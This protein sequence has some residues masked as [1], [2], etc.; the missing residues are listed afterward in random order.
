M[1]MF[2][3]SD[4][5]L[6][7]GLNPIRRVMP[8][9]MSGRNQ[10][11]VYHR[12]RWDSSRAR[13]WLRF[14]NRARPDQPQA[15]LFH[16][17]AYACMRTLLVRPGL[18]RFVSGGQVYQ[19]HGQWLS[20]ALKTKFADE[21][22]LTTVK[23]SFSE[24]ECFDSYVDRMTAAVKYGRSGR[25]SP[26]ERETRLLANLPN[27]LLRFVVAAGRKLDRFNLLPESLILPDPLFTSFFLANLGSIRIDNAYHHLYEYG[28]CS[29]FG[30]LGGVKKALMVNRKGDPEVREVLQINWSFDERVN[31]AFFCMK[32]LQLIRAFIEDPDDCVESRRLQPLG[33]DVPTASAKEVMR[34]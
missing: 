25:E 34:G 29:I 32:C 19:R 26:I 20:F 15:T 31:D 24:N 13:A 10:S 6:I 30:V 12:S 8:L 21:A 4:G 5:E 18:N 9:V 14:Y 1:P 23:L 33:V 3:R 28:T 7:T 11:L 2:R 16:L 17:V 27:P 22:P